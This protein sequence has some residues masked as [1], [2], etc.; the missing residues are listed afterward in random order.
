VTPLAKRLKHGGRGSRDAL[1]APDS[2]VDSLS[3]FSGDGDATKLEEAPMHAPQVESSAEEDIELYYSIQVVQALLSSACDDDRSSARTA[4]QNNLLGKQ[5]PVDLGTAP[6]SMQIFLRNLDGKTTTLQ[7][8]FQE[9]DLT[10]HEP[11]FQTDLGFCTIMGM[12]E[13]LRVTVD[14]S[15]TLNVITNKCLARLGFKPLQHEMPSKLSE[16]A[17]QSFPGHYGWQQL[18]LSAPVGHRGHT[19]DVDFLVVGDDYHCDLLLG[20]EFKWL[21]LKRRPGIYP[22]YSTP[23]GKGLLF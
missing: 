2:D 7:D 4:W 15:V 14:Q 6:A 22:N 1:P 19:S 17:A 13:I 5:S 8:N 9:F 23:S 11:P 20:C 3:D 18:N 16:L 12:V 21:T 10:R